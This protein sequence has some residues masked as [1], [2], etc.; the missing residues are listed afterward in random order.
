MIK[1][2]AAMDAFRERTSREMMRLP[3]LPVGMA[4]G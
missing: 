3:R 1:K 2:Q 4:G